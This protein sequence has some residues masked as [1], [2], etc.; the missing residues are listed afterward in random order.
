MSNRLSGIQCGCSRQPPAAP[1]RTASV[2]ELDFF[3]GS[4]NRELCPPSRANRIGF[5]T[6]PGCPRL[7]AD[8]QIAVIV[9]ALR[10]ESQ[11]AVDQVAIALRARVRIHSPSD[12]IASPHLLAREPGLVFEAV[13]ISSAWSI[14]RTVPSLRR[15]RHL[16]LKTRS[17]PTCVQ[18]R[19]IQLGSISR[20]QALEYLPSPPY[21]YSP[22]RRGIE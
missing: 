3:S 1:K 10:C 8:R 6:L 7:A 2:I 22:V 5:I 16:I 19:P 17:C 21:W 14:R 11:H 18:R 20:R 4:R 13:W 12:S 9:D 15:L